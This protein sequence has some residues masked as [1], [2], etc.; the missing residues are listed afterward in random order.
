MLGESARSGGVRRGPG[1]AARVE[2]GVEAPSPATRLRRPPTL[3]GEPAAGSDPGCPDARMPGCPDARMP[4]CPDARMPGCPDARMPGCRGG[5]PTDRARRSLRRP[6]SPGHGSLSVGR[7][8]RCTGLHPT[9]SGTVTAARLVRESVAPVRSVSDRSAPA[10]CRGR[11]GGRE[12][13]GRGDVNASEATFET[14]VGR[15]RSHGRRGPV[16]IRHRESST[17]ATGALPTAGPRAGRMP[18]AV[19]PR[20]RLHPSRHALTAPRRRAMWR[21]RC[22]SGRVDS[23]TS[24]S[25]VEVASSSPPTDG[26]LAAGRSSASITVSVG[27]LGESSGR[28][29][30]GGRGWRGL[31]W[32]RCSR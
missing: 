1:P 5:G 20:L 25:S 24:G 11:A 30:S 16:G 9:D 4:G 28:L 14:R 31:A 8:D 10:R 32:A 12:T 17:K 26:P 6:N 3:P 22:D 19:S 15:G 29:P 27:A 7:S 2:V 13:R 21:A 23:P 18:R